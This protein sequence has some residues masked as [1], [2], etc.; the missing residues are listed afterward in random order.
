MTVHCLRLFTV[1]GPRQRPD[2]AI[3]KFAR[4]LLAGEPITMYGDGTSSRDYT[5][6]DDI[7]DGIT[8]SLRR[9][10]GLDASEYEI[11]N[12][13]GSETTQLRDLIS[14]LGEALDTNPEIKQLPMP[15]GDVKRT[16]A[17]INKAQELLD[18][19]PKTPINEGLEKFSNWVRQ[20]YIGRASETVR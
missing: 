1:Y 6:V 4:Q 20:Y 8:A 5:Y 18:W 9:A 7:V 19:A 15:P 17:D 14:E 3:H 11:I 2:L 13:G 12:L 10:H 16:Y